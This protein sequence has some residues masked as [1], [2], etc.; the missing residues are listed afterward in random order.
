MKHPDLFTLAASWDFPAD[1][2][3]YDQYAPGSTANYGTDANFQVNY[4]LTAGFL[5]AHAAPFISNNRIWIGGFSAFPQDVTDYDAL[6]TSEGMLHT[7]GTPQALVHSWDS[8][9]V[10]NAL[11]GLYQDSLDQHQ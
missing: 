3:T 1:I 10:P 5:A 2:S 6:L 11:A 7:L 8:G 9:W 4:R